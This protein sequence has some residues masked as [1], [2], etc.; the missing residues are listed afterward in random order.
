MPFK[1]IARTTAFKSPGA[2]PGGSPL[3]GCRSGPRHPPCPQQAGS[4]A[5]G[6]VSGEALLPVRFLS[7]FGLCWSMG[8]HPS[9]TT[10]F[11]P[12]WSTG[13]HQRRS[14]GFRPNWAMSLVILLHLRHTSASG[15]NGAGREVPGKRKETM[16][17]REMLRHLRRGQSNRAVA[18]TMGMDRKTVARYRT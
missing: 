2:G 7:S 10:R 13:F 11:R 4:P 1:R 5:K 6:L 17:V 9:W 18:K 15:D 3:V 8:F 14:A 12:N 16:D